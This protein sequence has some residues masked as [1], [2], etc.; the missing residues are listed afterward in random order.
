MQGQNQRADACVQLK[1]KDVKG[2]DTFAAKWE[3]E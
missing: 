2:N 1:S 3:T